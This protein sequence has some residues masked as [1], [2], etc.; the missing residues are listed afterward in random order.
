[1]AFARLKALP[2]SGA[3]QE[4][5]FPPTG[6]T[7]VISHFKQLNLILRLWLTCSA[8]TQSFNWR[9]AVQASSSLA[10][11]GKMAWSSEVSF[12]LSSAFAASCSVAVGPFLIQ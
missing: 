11:A 5:T 6:C 4:E 3:V 10:F 7:A 9:N 12:L 2:R 8:A 1:M